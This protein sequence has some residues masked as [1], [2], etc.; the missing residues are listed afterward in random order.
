MQFQIVDGYDLKCVF[1]EFKNKPEGVYGR[2]VKAVYAS[3]APLGSD[4]DKIG[5]K[6][7]EI[8]SDERY[9]KGYGLFNISVG[10]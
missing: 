9:H 10:R 7:N 8:A 1:V 2:I 6:T 4:F 3:N 5:H